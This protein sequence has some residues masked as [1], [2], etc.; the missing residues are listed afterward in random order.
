MV[1]SPNFGRGGCRRVYARYFERSARSPMKKTLNMDRAY[2]LILLTPTITKRTKRV[3][4][5]TLKKKPN[6]SNSQLL[7]QPSPSSLAK[8]EGSPRCFS[9]NTAGHATFSS[10]GVCVS[11]IEGPGRRSC[12]LAATP[13]SPYPYGQARYKRLAKVSISPIKRDQSQGRWQRLFNFIYRSY[14][15]YLASIRTLKHIGLEIR[16]EKVLT[17]YLSYSKSKPKITPFEEV[18]HVRILW[19]GMRDS[20]LCPLSAVP[21]S[22]Q[23]AARDSAPTNPL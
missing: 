16:A 9:V 23:A 2:C 15:F 7:A 10:W 14:Y 21:C 3:N 13:S 20:G 18:I 4:A 1:S 8:D 11:W 12:G 19:L 22:L 6:G 5:T 17:S